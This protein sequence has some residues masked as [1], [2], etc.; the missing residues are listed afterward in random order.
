MHEV[1]KHVKCCACGGALDPTPIALHIPV[2]ITWEFPKWGNFLTGVK[3]QGIA[4]ICDACA[5][6][7]IEYTN[8]KNVVELF[9]KNGV[10]YHPITWVTGPNNRLTAQLT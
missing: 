3:D 1:H 5:N 7:N 8:V 2:L 6:K 9:S 4:Y 10:K